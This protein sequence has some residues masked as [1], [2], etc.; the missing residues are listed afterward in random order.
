MDNRYN[1]WRHLQ[2]HEIAPPPGLRERLLQ[3]L[4]STRPPSDPDNNGQAADLQRLQQHPIEP[5]AYIRIAV[6]DAITTGSLNRS[7]R[8]LP[9]WIL[10]AAA[11]ACLIVLLGLIFIK[12]DSHNGIG[13]PINPSAIV[14]SS[15]RQSAT[16]TPDQSAG[17]GDTSTTA[18]DSAAATAALTIAASH[19][20]TIRPLR[21][22]VDH[23][24]FSLVD[25]NLLL[26]FTS[27]T[28]PDLAD[29]ISRAQDQQ[30]R[31]QLDQYTSIIISRPMLQT[32]KDMYR[33]RSNGKPT[34]KARKTRERLESLK[35]TDEKH[36]DL[37]SSANATDPL[38]LGD[39]ILK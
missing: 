39:F 5:P 31:V 7:A 23:Q 9:R 6:K 22:N 26:T 14:R 2:D 35:K 8:R 11:A 3:L 15:T 19:P 4:A 17:S 30:L 24:T 29:R 21:L 16:A 13:H 32:I 20:K 28:Y 12:Q 33:T 37:G 27:F 36:F 38:D 25:N 10:Y 34:R 18:R 1:I